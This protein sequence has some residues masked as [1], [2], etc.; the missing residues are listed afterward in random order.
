MTLNR[1]AA[2]P[3]SVPMSSGSVVRI[4]RVILRPDASATVGKVAFEQRAA[5]D[6]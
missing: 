1:L 5:A 2:A 4:R 3:A 6:E